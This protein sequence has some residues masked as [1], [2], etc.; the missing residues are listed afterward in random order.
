MWKLITNPNWI[1]ESRTTADAAAMTRIVRPRCVAIN[2]G[3]TSER[4]V[5]GVKSVKEVKGVKGKRVASGWWLVA[6]G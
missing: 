3:K 5:R 6:G 2:G 4:E 1:R